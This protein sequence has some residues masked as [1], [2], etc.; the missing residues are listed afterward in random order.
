TCSGQNHHARDIENGDAAIAI[1]ITHLRIGRGNL[2]R[3][4]GEQDKRP[5]NPAHPATQQADSREESQ[6]SAGNGDRTLRSVVRDAIAHGLR[7]ALA[8]SSD[9][10][11][12]LNC[13]C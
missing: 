13:H 8:H 2:Q 3:L 9:K 12:E 11:Q 5:Q 10:R 6:N 1:Q 4:E 7:D